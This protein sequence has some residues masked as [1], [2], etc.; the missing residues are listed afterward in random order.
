LRE[1]GAACHN[2]SAFSSC[3]ETRVPASRFGPSTGT[4]IS[5][6]SRPSTRL[7]RFCAL[8][9]VHAELQRRRTCLGTKP[10]GGERLDFERPS[11]AVAGDVFEY[12]RRL[13][14]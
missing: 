7:R 1:A 6:T 9:F 13:Q 5:L 14:L 10:S 12:R 2:P 3:A 11:D 4:M 8:R